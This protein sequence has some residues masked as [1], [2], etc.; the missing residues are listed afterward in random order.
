VVSL[1]DKGAMMVT[2]DATYFAKPPKVTVKSTVGAGDSMV[3][4]IIFAIHQGMS[5]SD[6]L[7]FGVACGTAATLNPGT[8]LC[9]K[10]DAEAL[11][12]K[13]IA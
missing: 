10:A 12:P 8:E 6:S 11:F 2:K 1:A 7:R 4:G 9:Y 13:V 3:A 5:L